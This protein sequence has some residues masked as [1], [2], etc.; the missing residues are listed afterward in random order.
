MKV[1]ASRYILT[2]KLY[3]ADG[4]RKGSLQNKNKCGRNRGHAS[5]PGEN[6]ALL[7]L[8]EGLRRI[9]AAERTDLRQPPHLGDNA[10]N[11]WQ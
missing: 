1:V 9:F 2:G 7:K 8:T 6:Q 5:A 11:C 3:D 10:Q 4:R